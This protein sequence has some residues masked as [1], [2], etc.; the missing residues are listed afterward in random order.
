MK[1]KIDF[2]QAREILDS[3]GNPTVEVAIMLKDG[4]H[5]AASVPSGA[6]TGIHEALELRDGDPKRFNGKGVL[7]AVRNVNNKIFPTI[8]GFD[9]F[10]LEKIDDTMRIL[11]GTVNKHRLGANA[12][13]GVSMACAR[14]GAKKRGI[15]LYRHLRDIYN[16]HFTK[17]KLPT[18][19]MNV[20]NGGRHA[21]TNLDM[22]EFIIIP[23]GFR[24]VRR[25]IRAGAEIF[26]ALGEVLYKD[27]HDLD[28][29]NEG[30]YA[31]NVGKT[32]D[33]LAYLKKAVRKAKYKLGKQIGFG[34]DVAASEFY[35][36]KKNKYIL[37]TDRKKLAAV[38]MIDLLEKKKKKYPLIS[39]EDGLDQDDWD[40]WVLLTKRLGK[41][42]MII[43]DDLFVTNTER[44]QKGID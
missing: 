37:R 1:E 28:V 17:F 38:E 4:T 6:S 12:I 26:H 18:P 33:A 5:A 29:G 44:L 43:G 21:S 11:D 8:K 25:K 13:L 16:L 19:L 3:R 14:V 10:D 42:A 35:D 9:V 36:E 24:S 7:K 2:I 40:N 31:P 22:Q 41:K 20:F 30:G 23:H 34:I 27:G 15:P 39:I 32:E